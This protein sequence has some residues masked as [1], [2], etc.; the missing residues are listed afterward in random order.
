MSDNKDKLL[1]SLRDLNLNND[2]A[3]VYLEL[4]H[5]PSNHLRLSRTTGLARTKV[6][7][8]VEQLEKRSLVSKR[9]DDRGPLIIASDP[10]TLEV[11]LIANEEKLKQ[12]RT[13]LGRLL[14]TLLSIQAKDDKLFAVRT[15]EGAEGL[16]QMC[17]HELK[18]QGDLL[19]LGWGNIEDQ[20]DDLR[21]AE[22]HRARQIAAG[23]HTRELLTAADEPTNSNNK[24]FMGK[25]YSYRR[26]PAHLTLTDNQTI[27][28]NDTV[29]IYHWRQGQ[30]VGVEIINAAYAD[31]MRQIFE[32]YWELSS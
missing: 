15:Y 30:K 22:R 31:M 16:R 9:T 20:M 3:S 8:I 21:W 12:Q 13:I 19:S 29:A 17:W 23:Y 14:P 2:E 1:S 28:Y 11:D 24:E 7:R 6:Y 10:S 4:L 32:H 26:L 25:L 18:S 5:A 27:I